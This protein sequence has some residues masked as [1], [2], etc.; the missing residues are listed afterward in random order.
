MTGAGGG[1]TVVRLTIGSIA[2]GWLM[3]FAAVG[4]ATAAPGEM[5]TFTQACDASGLVFTLDGSLLVADDQSD[6][7]LTYAASGGEPIARTDLYGLTGTPP[8]SRNNFS[9]FEGAARLGDMIYFVTSH[10]RE[11]KGK[12][13]PNRR[14]LLAVKST[15]VGDAERLDPVGIAYTALN[16]DLGK[17]PQLR[18]LGLANAIMQLHR[19]LPHLAPGKNGINIEGLAAGKNGELLIGLRNPRTQGLTSLIPLENPHSV[20]LGYGEPVFGQ[21]YRLD[22]GGLGISD[23]ALHPGQGVYYILATPHDRDA[24]AKLYRWSG[25]RDDPAVLLLDLDP[26]DFAAQALAVAPDGKRLMVLSDDGDRPLPI[27][28]KEECSSRPR[29][30]GECACNKIVDVSRKQFRGRWIELPPL[31]ISIPTASRPAGSVSATP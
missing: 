23:I 11:E 5:L 14:R 20:V 9:A 21:S 15:P 30:E 26:R 19:Q 6:I 4:P 8:R 7:L 29:K 13:R 28:K 12:N 31:P 22:L 17:A 1:T 2:F 3:C 18:S 25:V 10:A 27:E 24:D 16:V